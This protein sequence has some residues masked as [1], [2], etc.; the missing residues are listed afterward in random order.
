MKQIR[1]FLAGCLCVS[2]LGCSDSSN[3]TAVPLYEEVPV[4]ASCKQGQLS[5]NEK[6]VVLDYINSVRALYKLPPVVNSLT[7]N[8][9][10]QRLALINAAEGELVEVNRDC[11]C[12][13]EDGLKGYY[14]SA[15]SLFGFAND[16]WGH[17]ETHIDDFI[18][19]LHESN[20]KSRRIILDPFLESVAFGRVIGTP[21]KGAYKYV[22]SATL[23]PTSRDAIPDSLGYNGEFVAF[24]QGVCESVY[25]DT[26]ALSF[27]V[28]CDKSKKAINGDSVNFENV[29]VVVF[30][31]S[32]D[33]V[34]EIRDSTVYYDNYATGYGLPNNLRWKM[35][36]PFTK[37][38]TYTVRISNVKI[39]VA[40]RK[41]YEYTFSFK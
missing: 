38:V 10:A 5:D 15:R 6:K 3:E 20:L 27:S 39:G 28:V 37:G 14:Y 36:Q 31:N 1:F 18:K 32:A 26:I 17:S 21:K 22:S 13:S 25:L 34:L 11:E 4:I 40:T 41:D 2:L 7:N 12:W 24:P 30:A 16:D 19:D 8:G 29:K 33:N 23:Y 35:A 9:Y